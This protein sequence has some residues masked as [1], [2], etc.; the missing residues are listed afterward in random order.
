MLKQKTKERRIKANQ[1]FR[2]IENN[3]WLRRY[4][5]RNT[6]RCWSLEQIS[7]RLKQ[8]CKNDKSK[9]IGKDCSY[10]YIY[11]E[12]KDLVKYLRC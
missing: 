12:R 11:N 5:I 3:K 9:Q 10:K 8:D 6:K 7:G 4:I 1:R 2:K